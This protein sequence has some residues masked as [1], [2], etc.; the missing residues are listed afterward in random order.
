MSERESLDSLRRLNDEE[1]ARVAARGDEGAARVLL[2]R[3]EEPLYRYTLAL[4]R[5]GDLAREATWS[6]LFEAA[7]AVRMDDYSEPVKPW[8]F[9]VAHTA[10]DVAGGRPNGRADDD[11]AVARAA[12]AGGEDRE[13][14]EAMLDRLDSLPEEQ[15]G[16]L[17]LRELVGLEYT[18]IAT[19]TD[20]RASAAR[21]S[22]FHARLAMQDD[23]EATTEHCDEIRAA[24]SKAEAGVRERRSISLH[25][26][27]CPVCEEFARQL[28][29]RPDDLRTL[30]PGP[31]EPLAAELLP[32]LPP[33]P[34]REEAVTAVTPIV[35]DEEGG[36]RRRRRALLIPAVIALVLAG[37]GIATALILNDS[38]GGDKGNARAARETNLP[39]TTAPGEETE[40]PKEEKSG[41]LGEGGD[42]GSKAGSGEGG[43]KGSK[44]GSA[45]GGADEGS[46]SGGDDGSGGGGDESS[47]SGGDESSGSGGDQGSA[48]G[49]T[50]G[51]SDEGSGGTSDEG[52]EAGS[53]AGS[54]ETPGEGSE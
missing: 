53:S 13:R 46:E 21:A 8:L 48:A 9:R 33:I 20:E 14:M 10:A 32:P 50:G 24:M 17:L 34:G 41:G 19:V 39:G 45:G 43:D 15:R 28:E 6:T 30:F 16:A 1:L 49:A 29:T 40:P 11:E 44:A 5:D 3:F 35:D 37:A 25:L 22:V 31:E 7:R 38:G 26:E 12:A 52:S 4:V 36:G 27:T 23:P 2:E 42:E 51:T 54:G 18:G 47:A